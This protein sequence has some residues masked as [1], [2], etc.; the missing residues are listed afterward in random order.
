MKKTFKLN[1]LSIILLLAALAVGIVATGCFFNEKYGLKKYSTGDYPLPAE[2][3]YALLP[4][5]INT[6]SADEL[7]SVDGITR[8]MA[9]NIVIYRGIHPFEYPEDI[10]DVPGITEKD[11]KLFKNSICVK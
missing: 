9:E 1:T 2:G 11:Y 4:A 8:E 7:A 6:A 10:M 5:D 3:E